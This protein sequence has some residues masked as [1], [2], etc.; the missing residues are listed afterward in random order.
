[1]KLNYSNFIICVEIYSCSK[2]TEIN[3]LFFKNI[4]IL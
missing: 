4:Y 3:K 1:M 2:N